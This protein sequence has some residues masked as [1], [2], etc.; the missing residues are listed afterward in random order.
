MIDVE[1]AFDKLET[2]CPRL[3]G[4]VDFLYCRKV[5]DNL[6]CNR[7]LICWEMSFPVEIYLRKT[8][9]PEEWQMVFERPPQSRLE[10]ILEAAR[11]PKE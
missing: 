10:K 2:R 4:N 1:T 8:M 11:N 9:T 6:P 7:A 5:A 3:G